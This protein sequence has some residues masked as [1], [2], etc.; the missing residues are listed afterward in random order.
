MTYDHA[1]EV[2]NTAVADKPVRYVESK[3]LR[4]SWMETDK[5]RRMLMTR[6]SPHPEIKN[7]ATG[8]KKKAA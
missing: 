5:D 2:P 6:S 1:R 4:D 3:Q 7:T 8:G